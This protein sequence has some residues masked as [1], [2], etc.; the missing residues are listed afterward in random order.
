[1]REDKAYTYGAN[2]SL[3]TNKLIGSFNA[4]A[5]VRN[6]VTDSAIIEFLKEFRTIRTESVS[7]ENLQLIKNVMIGQFSRSLE[8][9]GTIANFALN[10]VR[11]KLAPDYY[12]NYL[13]TLQN[14]TPR[15]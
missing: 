15:M 10:T 7:A 3:S 14:V 2:S 13:A 4:G 8:Q 5:S 12:E 9:P 11:Y 1:M 6:A